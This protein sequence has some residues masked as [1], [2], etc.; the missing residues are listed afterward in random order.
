MRHDNPIC[1]ELTFTCFYFRNY[2][3]VQNKTYQRDDVCGC[4]VFMLLPRAIPVDARAGN[5]GQQ[6]PSNGSPQPLFSVF[7]FVFTLLEGKKD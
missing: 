7:V 6:T 3:Y 5:S 4:V 2:I 1:I